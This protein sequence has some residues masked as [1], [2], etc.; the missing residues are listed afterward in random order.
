MI[1]LVLAGA[2][3]ACSTIWPRP[4]RCE[5]PAELIGYPVVDI[6]SHTFNARYL[7]I[8]NI[9]KARWESTPE[10]H[11]I[12][13]GLL[14]DI[15]QALIAITPAGYGETRRTA[16]TPLAD[17]EREARSR[18]EQ[19]TPLQAVTRSSV[20]P[21]A[22]AQTVPGAKALSQLPQAGKGPPLT[23]QKLVTVVQAMLPQ[24]RNVNR[25]FDPATV[26]SIAR[27]VGFLTNGEVQT[28]R[29][30]GQREFDGRVSLFV[31]HTMD[32]GPVFGE[33]PKG[34]DFLNFESEQLRRARQFDQSNDGRFLHF[35]AWNPFRRPNDPDP[36]ADPEPL[37][38]VKEAVRR[39]AWGVKFYPPS[40]YRPSGNDLKVVPRPVQPGAMRDQWDARYYGL[41][42]GQ[43]DRLNDRLFAWCEAQHVPIFSHCAYGEFNAAP[44]YGEKMADPKYWEPVLKNHPNL[45]LCLAHAGGADFWF[46]SALGH[47]DWGRTVV[48]LVTQFDHVFCEYGA[49]DEILDAGQR[50]TFVSRVAAAIRDS[51]G[52]FAQRIMYG[53]DWFMPT[54]AEPRTCFLDG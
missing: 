8:E 7:P 48:R 39:G 34:L 45:Y 52:K 17:L 26:R 25:K 44:G 35:V 18:A 42:A 49:D 6:H 9:I 16:T 54:S 38:L 28:A 33:Q 29:E 46:N 40:G 30:L 15:G 10:L 47:A 1:P 50:A 32:L 27:F 2:V 36:A 31:H 4:Q 20:A 11:R 43:L 51:N 22:P 53:S 3:P 13:R 12:D 37:R 24:E 21:D 23:S 14:L 41:D 19:L 5:T